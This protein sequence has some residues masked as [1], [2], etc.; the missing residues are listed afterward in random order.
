MRWV[1][2]ENI[3]HQESERRREIEAHRQPKWTFGRTGKTS[4]HYFNFCVL[5]Q[6]QHT[7]IARQRAYS[8]YS[9]QQKFISVLPRSQ[10]QPDRPR[11]RP[12][13]FH[14][15]YTESFRSTSFFFFAH[16]T[17][18]PV[19]ERDE[20]VWTLSRGFI[21]YN[22]LYTF[23]HPTYKVLFRITRQKLKGNST[24]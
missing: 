3:R 23:F 17:R 16:G 21:L 19:R 22:F 15:I 7:V 13:N 10:K 12:T 8:L 5:S 6:Q 11:L 14:A 2:S 18:T 4:N 20:M 9:T 1:I 24:F